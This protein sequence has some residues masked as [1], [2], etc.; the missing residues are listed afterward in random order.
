L[1]LL[2]ALFSFVLSFNAL[3]DLAETHGVSIPVLFP[4]TVEAGVVIFSLNALYRSLHGE[5]AKV[6]WVL[7]IGSSLLAGAFNILHAQ[8]DIVSRIMA[9]MPSLF[10]LLS[11]ETFLGQ[12]KHAVKRSSIIA[13]IERLAIELEQKRSDVDAKFERMRSTLRKRFEQERSRLTVEIEQARTELDSKRLSVQELN[14]ELEQKRSMVTDLESQ[15]AELERSKKAT[16]IVQYDVLNAVNAEKLNEKQQA[17]NALLNFYRSNPTATLAEAGEAIERS[18]GTVSNYL[19]EL[20]QAGLIR[21]NGQG[22]KVT[23]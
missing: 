18:K 4:L 3:T 5:N 19:N 20:E 23:Q 13:S 8:A 22:V 10:L 17:L 11:F 14:K 2:L 15:M 1:T 12:V 16:S 9:A 7:I 6:Q 21:R